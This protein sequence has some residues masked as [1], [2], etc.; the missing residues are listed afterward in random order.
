M[1]K[2]LI[3]V[4]LAIVIA[5]AVLVGMQ[6]YRPIPV[7]I[8]NQSTQQLPNETIDQNPVKGKHVTVELNESMHFTVK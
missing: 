6:S 7:N 1:N 8:P 4:G 5:L 3:V 2:K